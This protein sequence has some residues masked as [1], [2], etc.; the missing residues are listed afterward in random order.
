MKKLFLFAAV[1]F[2]SILFSACSE[3][4][5]KES[6]TSQKLLKQ[7]EEI[8]ADKTIYYDFSYDDQQRLAEVSIH[9]GYIHG[10]V[11]FTYTTVSAL[12]ITAAADLIMTLHLF[13]IITVMSPNSMLMARPTGDMNTKTV[14]CPKNRVQVLLVPF[15]G[16]I[17]GRTVI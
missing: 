13:L 7:I 3:D 4:D 9:G 6:Q 8:S 5:N 17:V 12:N 14:M 10:D 15:F 11:D 16:L 2:S 1:M